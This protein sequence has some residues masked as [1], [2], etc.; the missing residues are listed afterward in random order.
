MNR[1]ERSL[2][3]LY[4]ET[5]HRE[6]KSISL[7][8]ASGSWRRYYRIGTSGEPVI[9]VWNDDKKENEAFFSFTDHFVRNALPVPKILARSGKD[10]AYLISDLGD[11]T[12]FGSLSEARKDLT[13]FPE[14]VIRIYRKVISFLPRFQVEAAQGLNYSKCYPRPAFDRQSMMWDLNYFKYYFLKLAKIPFDEQKLEDDFIVLTDY[15][16]TADCSYFMYR[17]FQSR[18]VMLV[19]SEPWFI[20]YQGG[21]KGPLHYDI[22]SLLYDAKA[23]IPDAVRLSL[24]S[25]Y[26]DELGQHMRVDRTEFTQMFYGFVLIRI[27]Q[28]MG[29][30]GFRGYYENKPHFLQSIPYAVSNLEQLLKDHPIPVKIP[31]LTSVLKMIIGNPAFRHYKPALSSLVVTVTSFSFKKGIPGDN[32]G[33]G[34]GFVFDCR[35]LPNP[36]KLEEFRD[37][38]GKDKPV[39]DFLNKENSVDEFLKHVFFLVDRSVERYIERDFFSL[40]VAFGCTGGQHRSVYCAEALAKHLHDK[41]SIGVELIHSEAKNFSAKQ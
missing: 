10:P 26:L 21:R 22:A 25:F 27:L 16:L 19:N 8:P 20:D 24:L 6:A 4:K 2:T 32:T 37:Q 29:A 35:A 31:A 3:E 33:H 28:A 39:A 34:G 1:E 36:G 41:Y 13:D 38:T 5:F 11:E 15:L 40:S 9:G 7:L 23:S 30:Y 18:N 14:E 12:L 17:D